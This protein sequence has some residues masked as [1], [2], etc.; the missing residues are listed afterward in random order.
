MKGKVRS[1]MGL[2]SAGHKIMS[3]SSR[4]IGSETGESA[5]NANLNQSALVPL[6]PRQR[7]HL[8]NH[9]GTEMTTEDYLRMAND[10]KQGKQPAIQNFGLEQTALKEWE[11]EEQATKQVKSKNYMVE[12]DNA[13]RLIDKYAREERQAWEQNLKQKGLWTQA[14]ERRSKR[15]KNK[16]E[17]ELYA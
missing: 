3:K 12:V 15:L 4:H 14:Q 13:K 17:H 16:N 2:I 6:G 11:M 9:D 5:A 1:S 8:C 10:M 7:T